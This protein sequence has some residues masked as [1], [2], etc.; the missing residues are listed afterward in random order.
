MRI[1]EPAERPSALLWLAATASLLLPAAG[2]ALALYGIF[3][4]VDDD[5][6]GWVWVGVG[7]LVIVTDMVLDWAWAGPVADKGDEPTLNR[8]GAELIGQIVLVVE[9]IEADGRGK[10]R[11][12]DT[13]WTAEGVKA[14][15]GKRV[16]V[17]GVKGTVLTVAAT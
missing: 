14:A 17:V 8:R 9:P 1:P 7:T 6:S 10:V 4:I 13:V 3:R 12:A 2:V 5:L 11:A 16:R 15:V